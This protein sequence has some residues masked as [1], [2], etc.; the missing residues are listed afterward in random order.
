MGENLWLKVSFIICTM[1]IHHNLFYEIPSC[2]KNFLFVAEFVILGN[3]E[4][5]KIILRME[6]FQNTF[7]YTTF[8][9]HF[10][11]KNIKFR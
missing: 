7:F 11:A 6:E 9:D 2:A 8:H 3:Y 5:R 10:Q 1:Y 4:V